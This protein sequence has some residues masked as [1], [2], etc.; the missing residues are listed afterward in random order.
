MDKKAHKDLD[1]LLQ[2]WTELPAPS[3]RLDAPV[4][5]LIAARGARLSWTE[6]AVDLLRELDARFARPQ[7]MATLVAVALL[8]GVGLAELRARNDIVR[9][10]AEMS[11]R[12]L[13]LLEPAG[14]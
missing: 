7:A 6:R 8:L 14:H 3:G 13:A 4:W 12:Y 1:P 9:I 11:A 10:D 5:L 2:S